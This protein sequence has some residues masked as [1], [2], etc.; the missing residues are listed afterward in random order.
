MTTDW[1]TAVS[2]EGTDTEVKYFYKLL[3][4]SKTKPK[5]FFDVGANEGFY[6][7]AS[8]KEFNNI[9]L[10]LFEAAPE[11]AKMLKENLKLNNLEL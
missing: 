11:T 8:L 9:E 10:H 6:S 7:I 4:N 3:L 1:H 5:I 2:V